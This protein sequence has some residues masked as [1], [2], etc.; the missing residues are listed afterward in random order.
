M[1][2]D[3]AKH[4]ENGH[5]LGLTLRE[6]IIIFDVYCMKWCD[7]LEDKF[8]ILNTTVCCQTKNGKHYYFKRT[9]VCN[10]LEIFDGARNLKTQRKDMVEGLEYEGYFK[11]PK[12]DDMLV[13]PIDKNSVCST[14]T[15]GIIVIPPSPNKTWIN[16][17]GECD[18]QGAPKSLWTLSSHSNKSGQQG[19]YITQMEIQ[20]KHHSHLKTTMTT[21]LK[22]NC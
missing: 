7:Y 10:E 2:K 1:G 17:L 3:G 13:I 15:G 11:Q 20:L 21:K 22:A 18:V 14:G 12:D 8:P 6:G 16:V 4:I 5:A 19:Q 9:A